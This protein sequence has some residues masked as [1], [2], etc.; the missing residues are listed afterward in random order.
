MR[1]LLRSIRIVFYLPS[2]TIERVTL[3]IAKTVQIVSSSPRCGGAC[4]ASCPRACEIVV[5]ATGSL[6]GL[7]YEC[8]EYE[9]ARFILLPSSLKVIQH[10][11]DS[12]ERKEVEQNIMQASAPL[13]LNKRLQ[14][15]HGRG[16]LGIAGLIDAR[17]VP[18]CFRTGVRYITWE[19]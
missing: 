6:C 5:Q 4:R 8:Y 9:V 16:G 14:R 7:N 19:T 11:G 18:S 1:N 13:K 3:S 12:A 17:N 10:A 15:H 2:S